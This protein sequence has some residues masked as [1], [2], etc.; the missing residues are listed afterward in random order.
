M[1]GTVTPRIDWIYESSQV[2]SGTSTVFNSLMPARSVFNARI[3]YANQD[4][5][6]TISAG[7]TNLFDKEYYLNVFDSQALGSPYTQA[8]PAPPRQWY[9]TIAK[10]F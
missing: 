4:N 2:I 1:H 8:Q 3:T 6:Y 9:L 10:N 5:D 7:A